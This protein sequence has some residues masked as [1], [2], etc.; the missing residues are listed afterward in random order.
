MNRRSNR[1]NVAQQVVMD[2]S[3]SKCHS[4]LRYLKRAYV[5][6]GWSNSLD[7]NCNTRPLH[8]KGWPWILESSLPAFQVPNTIKHHLQIFAGECRECVNLQG[9]DGSFIGSFNF[10]RLETLKVVPDP[11]RRTLEAVLLGVEFANKW[12]KC[13]MFAHVC[14]W[15][16]AMSPRN[17]QNA[18]RCCVEMWGDQQNY[19]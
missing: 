8:L 16:L 11:M 17:C 7:K 13:I 6:C 19:C 4:I 10:A 1:W 18:F 14:A 5:F 15:R 9:C 2:H 3:L 12:P